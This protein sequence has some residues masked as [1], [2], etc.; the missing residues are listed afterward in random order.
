MYDLMTLRL[1]TSPT[2][3]EE[4]YIH[5][6]VE[7]PKHSDRRFQFR[8]VFDMEIDEKQGIEQLCATRNGQI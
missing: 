7:P 2:A 5:I 3:W 6:D 4:L 8:C 1:T